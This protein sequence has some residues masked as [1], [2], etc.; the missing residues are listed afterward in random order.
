MDNRDQRPIP[1]DEA[2]QGSDEHVVRYVL[3]VSL[4]LVIIAFAIIYLVSLT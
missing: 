4:G 2:R 3:G 1:A